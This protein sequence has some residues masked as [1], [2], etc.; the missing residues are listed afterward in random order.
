[1]DRLLTETDGPFAGENGKPYHPWDVEKVIRYVSQ[2]HSMP[3]GAVQEQIWKN[4]REI[5]PE[6]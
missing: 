3:A 5:N 4:F 2:I 1:L 6:Q